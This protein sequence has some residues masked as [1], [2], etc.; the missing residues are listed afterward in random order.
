M[1]WR[2]TSQPRC[3]RRR[4]R[5]HHLS[6]FVPGCPWKSVSELAQE[7][8]VFTLGA[9]SDEQPIGECF[10]SL[11][12]AVDEQPEP[13]PLGL[14]PQQHWCGC[15]QAFQPRLVRLRFRM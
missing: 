9:M 10:L 8:V 15:V 1:L 11:R 5:Q 12:S 14:R 6:S 2:S 13:Q 7:G 3:D 4:R